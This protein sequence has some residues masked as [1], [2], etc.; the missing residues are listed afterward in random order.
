M[1]QLKNNCYF[2]TTVQKALPNQFFF[3]YYYYWKKQL[4]KNQSRI[5]FR[6]SLSVEPFIKFLL[7]SL[8][9]IGYCIDLPS[10]SSSSMLAFSPPQWQLWSHD[11][12]SKEFC[13]T[14][15]QIKHK[16]RWNKW[17]W[18]DKANQKHKHSK[19]DKW[20]IMRVPMCALWCCLI[21]TAAS[22]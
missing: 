17:S 7:L 19:S 9:S 10:M 20:L 16:H 15:P 12:P 3:N 5:S 14:Q 21:N 1:K 13:F 6:K 22:P 2:I 11:L 4:V 8:S 18:S